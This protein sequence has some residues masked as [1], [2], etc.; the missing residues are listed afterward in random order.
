MIKQFLCASLIALC[1]S[2]CDKETVS[3][4]MRIEALGAVGS[5]VKIGDDQ[6]LT[7]AHVVNGRDMIFVINESGEKQEAYV[8]FIDEAHDIAVLTAKIKG[9]V[10]DVSCEQKP[11]GTQY[12]AIGNPL[13]LKFVHSWGRIA[14]TPQSLYVWKSVYVADGAAIHGMSGGGVFS[15]SGS[16]IGVVVGLQT[17]N[18][19]M[20]SATGFSFI[21]PMSEICGLLKIDD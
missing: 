2:S 9:K 12:E 6:I 3:S 10:A 8:S 17:A 13:G 14:S 4:A 5:G 19:P 15:T 20:P 7:S 21:V 11:I 16:L 1:L 18:M